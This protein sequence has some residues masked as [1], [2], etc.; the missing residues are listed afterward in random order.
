[1]EDVTVPGA[2]M[3]MISMKSLRCVI[4]RISTRA[5]RSSTMKMNVDRMS[6]SANE[7]SRTYYGGVLAYHLDL[8]EYDFDKYLQYSDDTDEDLLN[9]MALITQKETN[10]WAQGEQ[11]DEESLRKNSHMYS[12]Y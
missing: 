10:A 12:A 8:Y 6:E 2:Q 7:L 11:G 1:M 4:T 9:I 5:S 3:V